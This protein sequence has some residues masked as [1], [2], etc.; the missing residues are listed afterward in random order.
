MGRSVTQQDAA[1]C[2]IACV[3]YVCGVSYRYALRKYFRQSRSNPAGYMCSDIVKA[4][5]RAALAYKTRH[6][7]GK[8]AEFTDKT[9]VFSMRSERYPMGHYLV[10][11]HGRWM[12]PWTNFP[13][14]NKPRSGFVDRL[15]AR[16]MYAIVPEG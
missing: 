1:G 6:V 13:D 3:A 16:A 7:R 2:A 4:L 10:R 11:D 15:P 5:S 14:I 8:G 12:N 9:I